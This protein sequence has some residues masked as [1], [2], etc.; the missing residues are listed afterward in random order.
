VDASG[1]G[2]VRAAARDG[3]GA[4]ND[5]ADARAR[6]LALLRKWGWNATGFQVLEPGFGYFFHADDA[7]VAYLDTGRAWVVAGA[8]IA[9]PERLREVTQAFCGAAEDAGRRVC[10]FAVEARFVAATGF[11]S[12]VV[13]EQARWDPREWPAALAQR[14]SV[15]EQLRRAN[16]KGVRVRVAPAAEMKGSAGARAAVEDL[17]AR[18][19]GARTMAKMRFLVDVQPFEFAEERRYFVAEYEGAVVGFLAAVPIFARSGWLFEDLLRDPH[20]PNGTT[21]LLIDQAM[22]TVAVEGSTFVTLGLAPL[23]GPVPSWLRRVRR[24]S[25]SLYDFD[26]LRA[27]RSKLAPHAWDPVLLAVRPGESA[28][29]A[30][31][32]VL[33]AFAGG[34]LMGFGVRTLLRGPRIAMRALALLLV[35]WTVLLANADPAWF[36][37]PGVQRAWVAFDV[38]VAVALLVLAK[39]WRG[40]LAVALG[41]A[42]TAD[43]VLT[44]FEA[45]AYNL[46]RAQSLST[47]LVVA[48]ACA[49]PALGAVTLWGAVRRNAHLRRA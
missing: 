42:I 14:R 1:G 47:W 44:A 34:T 13:G 18:W 17:V 12:V 37:S 39:W 19:L 35:P 26:G 31:Y 10:F 16:A 20:A 36:P 33:V 46:P 29:V 27:F 4:L 25:S 49:G 7:C 15:R 2:S 43:A 41:A 5:A 32:D 24:F 28:V 21:E 45:A 8:P 9:P 30:V 6:T 11:R 48:L 40:G 23:S 3:N 22:R 38:L